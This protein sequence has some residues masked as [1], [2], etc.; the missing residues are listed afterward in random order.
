MSK[1]P[2]NLSSILACLALSTG[3]TDSALARTA[4]LKYHEIELKVSDDNGKF[5]LSVSDE[6]KTK[7][8]IEDIAFNYRKAQ[9]WEISDSNERYISLTATFS[10]NAEFYR[11]VTDNEP[12]NLQLKIS[13][14][15][16]GF[17]LH[18][19]PEW[20]R[21]VTL[22]LKDLNDHIFGLTEGLQPDN[23]LSPDLR[24]AVVTVDVNAE[25]ASVHE[26]FA[27]AHSAFYISSLGYGA[28][29]DTF[30]RGTYGIAINGQHRIHHDTGT[31][32]WYLF[33]GDDGSEIHQAYYSL[34]GKPKFV[35]AWGLGPVGWRDQNDGGAKEIIDDIDR[36]SA[37]KMPFTSWFV[38]RPYSD[39][40]HGWS[41]MNFSQKFSDPADWIGKIRSHYNMEFMTWTTPAFF[42]A[43][44]FNTHLD[45][46]FSYLDVTDDTSVASFKSSLVKK[47][48]QYGV[49]GHKIDRAD[50]RF[51]VYES[52]QDETIPPAQR[53][54]LYTYL[55]AKMHDDV[56]SEHWGKDQVTF[57]RSAIHRSQ[58]YVS[59]IW[60]GDPR[61]TWEGLR[62]NFAN[63]ARSA[64]MGFPVWGTDV[65]GYQGEGFIPEDLDLRWMQ[66]GSMAG[67]FEIKLD[68]AGGEGRDRMPWQYDEDFQDTF[69][70]I[71]EDRMQFIPYLYSLA[72]SS[73][74]NGAL[75]QPLAY[76][77]L[78]NKQTYDIW[79]TF[80]VG[81]AILVAP[82]FE[83]GTKRSV[84]LP[85]GEWRDFDA[86]QRRFD[87][88][89]RILVE[90]PLTTLPRFV[91]AN[92]LFVTGNLYQGNRQLWQNDAPTLTIHAFPGESGSKTH[93]TYIDGFENDQPKVIAM[94]H[95]SNS[96][97]VE[98]PAIDAEKRIEIVLRKRPD[99]VKINGED[100]E[101][102]YQQDAQLLIVEYSENAPATMTISLT[103]AR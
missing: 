47:Q 13:K 49:K 97:S 94:R 12:R 33:F 53:R 65:G 59:A 48:L 100:T 6:N 26:N 10:P 35:P 9:N 20:G 69:R 54:N 63:A 25:E 77:H 30:A 78:Q 81:D 50:E 41:E 90:A 5:S 102:S 21:Q 17:R 55:M 82:V 23:R 39:G 19:A 15:D 103:D 74:Q 34:I 37:M 93:F 40:A 62:A 68:G 52:W 38:D 99:A 24:D 88:G 36:L 95:S 85:P 51:P 4:T 57:V 28:F 64:F 1:S 44:P 8:D 79:D 45:G 58:P 76:K 32:D 2:F 92:S 43:T 18:A 27:S 98:V 96:L 42:G 70:A 14:V 29:F 61:T 83:P 67:L 87:G 3:I 101:F 22:T 86:P 16:G 72:N 11:T 80:Y 73:A 7:L 71:L 89:Q 31:L 91:K 60:A 56:L 75:M 66:A 46:N 84:Y